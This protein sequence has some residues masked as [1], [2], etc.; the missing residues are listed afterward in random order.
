MHRPLVEV[1]A[2]RGVP[3]L[4]GK[5]QIKAPLNPVHDRYHLIALLHGKSAA[6]A[7]IV[8]NIDYK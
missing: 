6:W 2:V 7:K 5:H 4:G 1:D 8:L 3:V